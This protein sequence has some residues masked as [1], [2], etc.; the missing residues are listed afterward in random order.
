[1]RYHVEVRQSIRR[2]RVFNLDEDE[3]RRTVLDPWVRGAELT[4]GDQPFLPR[5]ALLR[6]LEGPELAT[7][8][9]AHGQGWNRAERSAQD[10]T[11][12]VLAVAGRLTAAAVLAP[13]TA[14]W[15]AAAA[16]LARLDVEALDWAP[17]RQRV[18]SWAG[19]EPPTGEADAGAVVLVCVPEPPQWW[20]VDAG[21]ALGA[22]GPK[23]VPIQI[24]P[25]PAPVA[26]RDAEVVRLGVGGVGLAALA[27]R[28]RLA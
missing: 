18:M 16:E 9:L 28:L 25:G 1:M 23:A 21:L 24:D 5:E 20:L 27:K 6:V 19:G 2:A 15:E 10:V 3:L 7:V 8:D 26:L 12:S 17:L 4:L 11:A 22:Y 14:A 13:T